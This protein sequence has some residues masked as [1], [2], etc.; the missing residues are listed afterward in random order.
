MSDNAPAF[1]AEPGRRAS[2]I[3]GA[4]ALLLLIIG[5]SM[6]FWAEPARLRGLD[7]GPIETASIP[8]GGSV[9]IGVF[10]LLVAANAGG[11]IRG[12]RWLL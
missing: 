12:L 5:F 8:L 7:A 10:P 9:A 2:R 3:A 6:P 1:R 11:A 4:S